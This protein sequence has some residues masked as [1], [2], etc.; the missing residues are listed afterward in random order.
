MLAISMA[1]AAI[2]SAPGSRGTCPPL[3][4]VLDACAYLEPGDVPETPWQPQGETV[5]YVAPGGN[6]GNPG[7][8]PQAPKRTLGGA[9]IL[10]NQYPQ[11]PMRIELAG[12]VYL[13]PV[14]HEYLEITRGNLL[15]EGKTGEEAVIRP[16]F[17][18][19]DPD[20]W[21]AAHLF[22]ASGP[23]ANLAF[24]NLTLEGWSNPFYL[25]APL[26]SA[27]MK[28]VS[29]VD[30]RAREFRHRGEGF[31]T[32]FFST[33]YLLSDVYD[34]P[35][36]FDPDGPGVKYQIEGLI[37]EDV[38]VE[39]A[40]IGVNIGDEND[41]NVKGM[42]ISDCSFRRSTGGNDTSLDAVAVVN[43]SDILVAGCLIVGPAGDGLDFKASDCSVIGTSVVGAGRN[44]VKFWRNGELIDSIVY[45]CT[46][47]DDGAVIYRQGPGRIVN[48]LIGSKSVGYCGTF[49]Y[50]T[51]AAGP[52]EIVNTVFIGLDHTF[53]LGTGDLAVRNCCFFDMPGGLFSGKVAAADAGE[54]NALPGCSGNIG[55]DPLLENAGEHSF[56]LLP[57]SPCVDAGTGGGGPL[58][59]FDIRGFCR[60]RGAGI[61]IG[62]LEFDPGSARRGRDFDGDGTD[63]FAAYRESDGRWT[64]RGFSAFSFGGEADVPVAGDYSGSG[65]A[66]PAVYRSRDGRWAVRGETRFYFGAPGDLVLPPYTRGNGRI[67][68]GFFRPGAGLWAYRGKTRFW[69]GRD[70]DQPVPADYSGDDSVEAAVF[71]PGTGCWAITGEGARAYYGAA[72]DMPVPADFNGDGTEEIAVYRGSNGS[73]FIRGRSRFFFGKPGDIPV[74]G[75]YD[76]DGSDDTGVL[77]G[78]PPRWFIRGMTRVFYGTEGGG[79]GA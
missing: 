12:G 16:S 35:D 51:D 37:L 10:A 63:D 53:Y 17:W 57:G 76:G 65:S 75:D 15:I 11:T 46:P 48:S 78:D 38:E 56:S 70:R 4:G 8:S 55:A 22:Q 34:G 60:P 3:S 32:E 54:L 49:A 18:P 28:N 47:I 72:S 68:A 19:G 13:R 9:V 31:I 44:A 62:P 67:D 23:Y 59:G 14:E 58:P 24:R 26:E 43:S 6:D 79:P 27:A 42:R 5:V 20:S 73:W 77:R 41:A 71:R 50:D 30:I 69:W 7:T 66:R 21:G 29:L 1:L 33:S 74:T 40:D 52:L 36:G 61:D 2:V 45:G 25:G 39:G 64:I